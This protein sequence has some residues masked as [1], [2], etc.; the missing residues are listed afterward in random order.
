LRAIATFGNLSPTSHGQVE[1]LLTPLRLAAHG[2]LGSFHQQEAQQR[3]AL[4]ADVAQSSSIAAGLFRWHQPYVAGD[5]L[6]TFESDLGFRSLI[7]MPEGQR[8][9][10]GM[11]AQLSSH[12]PSLHDLFQLSVQFLDLRRQLVE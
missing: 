6:G 2:D 1:K 10:S 3:V 4:L 12:G 8:A 5:L 9:N 11:R 7:R